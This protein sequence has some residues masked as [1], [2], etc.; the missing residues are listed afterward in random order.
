M[1]KKLSLKTSKDVTSWERFTKV[2][3]KGE[4]NLSRQ[5]E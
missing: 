2:G 4:I 3:S 5:E 1:N